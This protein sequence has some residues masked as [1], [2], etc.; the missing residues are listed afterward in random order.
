M[1]KIGV[2]HKYCSSEHLHVA[3]KL[4]KKKSENEVAKERS[5][6]QQ[7]LRDSWHKCESARPFIETLITLFEEEKLSD[8]DFSFLRNWL[9]KKAKGRF[10]KAST[11]L[12]Y[13]VQ[14]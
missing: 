10:F 12:M 7:L 5:L 3:L 14:Q 4:R 8:F 11:E 6:N 9:G 2:S 13:S 1:T